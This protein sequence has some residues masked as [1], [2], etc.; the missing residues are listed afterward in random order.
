MADD[1]QAISVEYDLKSSAK[2]VDTWVTV[3]WGVDDEMRVHIG[4]SDPKKFNP[5][6][7]SK[8]AQTALRKIGRQLSKAKV[9]GT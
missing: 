5:E 3:S 8:K 1:P 9:K 2:N 6:Q 7:L 4:K